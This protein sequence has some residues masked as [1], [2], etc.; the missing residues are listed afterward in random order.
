[1]RSSSVTF[2]LYNNLLNASIKRATT[3]SNLL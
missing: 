3:L 2:A 1:M